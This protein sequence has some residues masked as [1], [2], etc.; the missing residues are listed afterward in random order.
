[1]TSAVGN[2]NHLSYCSILESEAP[3]IAFKST[4]DF[5]TQAAVVSESDNEDQH[6][7]QDTA[8]VTQAESA[9]NISS[10]GDRTHPL[11]VT[12]EDEPDKLGNHPTFD[13]SIQEYMHWHYRLNHASFPTMLHM[14][15][16]NKSTYHRASH[17]S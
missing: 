6:M 14:T 7:Q 3:A 10:K 12:F 4:I 8:S 16:Q 5:N 11:L 1:M 13:D 2:Y 17:Q 15:W 9:N